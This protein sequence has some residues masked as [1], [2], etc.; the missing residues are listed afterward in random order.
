MTADQLSA[1]LEI[2]AFILITPE[3]LGQQR[4]AALVGGL[5]WFPQVSLKVSITSGVVFLLLL[6]L[7]LLVRRNNVPYDPDPELNLLRL[8]ILS[9]FI[10]GT[11][12]AG[13]VLFVGLAQ[14]L[15]KFYDNREIYRGRYFLWG[16]VLFLVAKALV[17]L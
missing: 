8:L 16:G 12:Q 13:A 11:V 15:V 4:L 3:F 10:L 14:Y 6:G 7:T 9:P 17:I 2:I 5:R 1:I